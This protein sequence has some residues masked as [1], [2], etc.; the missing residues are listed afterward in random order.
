MLPSVSLDITV[1]HCELATQAY[2][3]EQSISQLWTYEMFVGKQLIV[4][5]RSCAIYR[6]RLVL[7]LMHKAR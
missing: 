3:D 2:D 4:D 6:A 7:L 1:S 5:E